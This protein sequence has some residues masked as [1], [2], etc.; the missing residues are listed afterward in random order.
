MAQQGCDEKLQRLSLMEE[1]RQR[2][3]QLRRMQL[4]AEQFRYFEDQLRRQEQASRRQDE[5]PTTPTPAPS[6]ASAKEPEQT[7]GSCLS[8]GSK[9]HVRLDPNRNKTSPP[10]ANNA[11]PQVKPAPTL[12]AVQSEC[13][14][15]LCC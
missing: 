15:C 2:V 1:E 11:V 4:D 14:G 5:T 6:S 9:N 7:D 13:W 12:A 10:S 8:Q 3:A